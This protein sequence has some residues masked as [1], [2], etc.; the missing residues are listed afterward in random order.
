MKCI[1][2]P[3]LLIF[4]KYQMSHHQISMH[5]NEMTTTQPLLVVFLLIQ[6]SNSSF[7]IQIP[8]PHCPRQIRYITTMHI[9]KFT[10]SKPL[11]IV[12]IG[13]IFYFCFYLS[14]LSC[15]ALNHHVSL[16]EQY[17]Q[18]V[19]LWLPSRVVNMCI[20]YFKQNK[21]K[22]KTSVDFMQAFYIL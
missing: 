11:C 22:W 13:V 12:A 17:W 15:E 6:S 7:Q 16:L 1:S 4:D 3:I 20:N 8:C 18:M 10:R 2:H 9:Y 5:R 21:M 14:R 19:L